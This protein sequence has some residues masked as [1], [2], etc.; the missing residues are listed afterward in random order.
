[1]FQIPLFTT[2]FSYRCE[3]S[4]VKSMGTPWVYRLCQLD[5]SKEALII[6]WV[7]IYSMNEHTEYVLLKLF[8][9]AAKHPASAS[10][11][12]SFPQNDFWIDHYT[13]TP[14]TCSGGYIEITLSVH[15]S[16]FLSVIIPILYVLQS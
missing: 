16:V 1:M 4:M 5:I 12:I 2:Q 3:G 11:R 15:P 7:Q 8:V 13:C 10:C 6:L 9:S 14:T